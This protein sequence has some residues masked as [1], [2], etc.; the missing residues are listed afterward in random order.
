MRDQSAGIYGQSL[1]PTPLPPHPPS[2][3]L[4]PVPI[5]HCPFLPRPTSSL[6]PQVKNKG[7][8]LTLCRI[9]W[10]PKHRLKLH[11]KNNCIAKYRYFLLHFVEKVPMPNHDIFDAKCAQST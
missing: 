1:P 8:D 4:Y 3:G 9:D 2:S 5:S 7:D 11:A 10:L 6:S